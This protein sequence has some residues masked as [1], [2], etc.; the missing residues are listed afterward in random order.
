MKKFLLAFFIC[1][2][3]LLYAQQQELF[4]LYKKDWS[5]AKDLKEASFFMHMLK[6]NDT[7][8]VC[9]YYNVA[10]PMI[11]METYKDSDLSVP[12][13]TFSWFNEN[14]WLDS[15]GLVY[16]GRKDGNWY[17]MERDSVNVSVHEEYE[18]GRFQKRTDYLNKRTTYATGRIEP[19]K[20][21]KEEEDSAKTFTVVQVEAEFPKGLKGW[22]TYL[23]KNLKIPDRFTN[24]VKGNG[25]ATVVLTFRVDKTGNVSNVQLQRSAEWSVDME[26]IRVVRNSPK[27]EPATQ[28]GKPV[29]YRQRQS[30]TFSVSE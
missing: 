11:K 12:M 24:L 22:R 17:Y 18:R 14:G 2:S 8:F 1:N 29:I 13:G 4:F 7:S 9:R 25:R 5:D 26:A 15:T 30:I 27:W 28:D 10:G 23:E 6:E 19:F 3:S 20:Q 16:N 21:E